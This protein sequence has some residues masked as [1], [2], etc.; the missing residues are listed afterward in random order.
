[1]PLLQHAEKTHDY[2]LQTV[3]LLFVFVLHNTCAVQAARDR[4]PPAAFAVPLVKAMLFPAN[5][6]TT[7]RSI[8]VAQRETIHQIRLFILGAERRGSKVDPAQSPIGI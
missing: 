7:Q 6:V 1:M 2:I 5:D 3:V 8:L 4:K